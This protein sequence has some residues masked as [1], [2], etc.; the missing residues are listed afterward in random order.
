MKRFSGAS[1]TSAAVVVDI[2]ARVAA[3]NDTPD[4]GG[5]MGLLGMAFHP[6]FPTDPRVFLS[7]T[8]LATGQRQSRVSAF[9]SNDG[10]VTIDPDSERI[11]LTVNQPEANH[12]GGNI[13]F[14]K[15]GYLYV[16]FGDGGGGGDRHGTTGNAQNLNTLL[17]KMLRIDVNV[18]S[19]YGIP[20]DNPFAQNAKCTATGGS[21]ACPEIY[22]WGFRNPWRISY[23]VPTG[24]L[25]VA[26]VGQD[27]YEEIDVVEK[28]KN[29]GWDCREGKHPYNG[30]SSPICP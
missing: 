4:P 16:G 10:G 14:G 6:Q 13:A 19:G 17:G 8:T 5:E 21:N 25:W 27:R 23:D 3:P 1:A 26:D 2:S 28:G 15:D 29:Y 24:R 18:A 9:V 20:T 12:N 7:Y 11:L 22:A 30:E